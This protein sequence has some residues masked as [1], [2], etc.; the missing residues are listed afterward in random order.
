MPEPIAIAGSCDYRFRLV[1]EEFKRNFIERGEIGASVCVTV[2]G[3][4]VVDLWG[5]VARPS[6][7]TPWTRDTMAVVWSSTK[8]ATALCAHVLASRGLLDLEAPVCRYWPDFAR[9]GKSE[10]TVAQLLSHQAGLPAITER[11][12]NLA[13][14]DWHVMTRSLEE[15]H[16]LWP[17][18]TRHGYHGLTFGWLVG[19]VVRRVSSRSLGTFFRD[20]VA[21]PLDLDFWIGIPAEL[22]ARM[23]RLIPP[24]PA[25]PDEPASPAELAR[26]NPATIQA[27]MFGN[28]GGYFDGDEYDSPRA[29]AAEV[30]GTGGITNAKGLA[31]MYAPLAC[32]GRLNS[33]TLVDSD[34]LARMSAVCSAGL[35]ATQLIPSRIALGFM[36]S[37]DNSRLPTAMQDSAVISEEAFGHAGLGGSVGFADPAA[38]MSFGYVMNAMGRGNFLNERG[39]GLVDATYV[40]L[41][42]RSKSSGRWNV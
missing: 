24:R 21:R 3:Q 32:G 14:R 34:T 41:G 18:G 5:G 10:I 7:A 27:L 6:K 42:Y 11:L 23:A 28:S 15:Q 30:G 40:S 37:I 9:A 17:P 1:G 2:D 31:G 39:Q 4:T 19:E 36:K 16:P 22:E 8:G 35:D 33:T 25:G 20:E 13:Y 29:H 12:P 26:A 38:R